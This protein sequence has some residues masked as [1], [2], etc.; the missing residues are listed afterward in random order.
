VNAQLEKLLAEHQISWRCSVP[1]KFLSHW[2]IGGPADYV[3]EP[4]SAKETAAACQAAIECKT[5]WLVIGSG[6]NILFDDSGYRGLIIKIGRRFAKYQ[7]EGTSAEADAGIWMPLL[8]KA[9]AE[10]GLSGLEHTAGIP[11]NLGGLLY[12]NGGSMRRN[13]GDNVTWVKVMDA[14]GSVRKIP[15]NDCGFSYRHSV[16]QG[17]DLIILGARLELVQGNAGEIRREMLHVL[18]ERRQKFPLDRPNCGS[19]FSNDA[20]LYEQ[21]GPPG[22]VI[23]RLGLKGMRVGD[24]EV[25]TKHANFIVNMGSATSADVFALVKKVRGAIRERTGFTLSSEVLY[26]SPDG[27]RAPLSQFLD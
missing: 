23:D 12:M 6:S 1:L 18:E 24:A 5:P 10:R 8:A 3:V 14:S 2:R 17:R 9:S 7:F 26:V 27:R 19:V 15:K 13:I 22:M 11:G 20:E 21:Y 4:C 16:F 25:S